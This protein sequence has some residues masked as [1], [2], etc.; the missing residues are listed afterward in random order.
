MK[1]IQKYPVLQELKGLIRSQGKSYRSLSK[2]T[3]IS[4]DSLNNKLQSR[5]LDREQT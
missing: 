2:E 3:G 4:V 1:K 5:Y